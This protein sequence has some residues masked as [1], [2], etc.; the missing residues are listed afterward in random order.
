MQKQHDPSAEG[1]IVGGRILYAVQY[2]L[3]EGRSLIV[4]LDR[5]GNGLDGLSPATATRSAAS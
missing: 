5:A 3:A 2:N 4:W 1:F